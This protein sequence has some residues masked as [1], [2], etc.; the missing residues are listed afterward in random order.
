MYLHISATSQEMLQ[1]A[2]DKV[3]ELIALD[4]GSLVEDKKDRTRERVCPHALASHTCFSCLCSANGL[5]RR[6]PSASR[7]S[8]T[9]TSEQRWSGLRYVKF[10]CCSKLL[11]TLAL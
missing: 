8:G 5:K 2:I 11:L 1:K 6:Y 4:M 3:N 9:S 7:V 10:L